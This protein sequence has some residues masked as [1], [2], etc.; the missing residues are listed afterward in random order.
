M[1][2][3]N[4]V[5]TAL[6]LAIALVG[7]RA[8]GE[9][10]E[11]FDIRGTLYALAKEIAP[12]ARRGDLALMKAW[13]CPRLGEEVCDLAAGSGFLTQALTEWLDGAPVLAIDPSSVQL[14]HLKR[15]VPT[16][17]TVVMGSD[18]LRL[19]GRVM[20][21]YDVVTSF[22]G[23]HHAADHA[24]L[25]RNIDFLLK[26]GGRCVIGDI[27]EGSALA[28]HFD[29]VVAVK[30]LT[31]HEGVTWWSEAHIQ[32]LCEG[33]NLRLVR[34]E[35]VQEH[36]WIFDSYEQL[37]LFFRALHA[38]DLSDEE[39]IADLQGALGVR[40]VAGKIQLSWPMYLFE[41]VKS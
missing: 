25:M 4:R 9:K 22:G 34:S 29:E 5:R 13:I 1:N 33:T 18:D 15:M 3:H 36:V 32:R 12:E 27:Q 16:A 6:D 40:E 31:G 38:Y 14:D 2:I 20:K 37:A 35:L 39:I 24:Q 30:C 41:L 23:L 10:I 17:D 26:P 11:D 19:P 21:R 28:R 8:V 7:R